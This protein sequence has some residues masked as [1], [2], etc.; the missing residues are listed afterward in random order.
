M[1]ITFAHLCDYASVSLDGK[2]SVM[3]IFSQINGQQIPLT[4]PQ[5]YLAFQI[6][7]NYAEIGRPLEIEIQIVDQDGKSLF[8]AKGSAAFQPGGPAPKPGKN[9][10]IGQIIA[11]NNLTF[12]SAGTYDI[13]VFLN[14][15]LSKQLSFEVSKPAA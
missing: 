9:G 2:L 3:G 5:A 10:Q 6:D 12:A 11:F 14:G 13:N 7:L 8:G 4:H 1:Q 15:N